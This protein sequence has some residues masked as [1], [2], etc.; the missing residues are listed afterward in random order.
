VEGAGGS[1][2]V[3]LLSSIVARTFAGRIPVSDQAIEQ[4][5]EGFVYHE[6]DWWGDWLAGCQ[7]HIAAGP[8]TSEVAP[9]VTADTFPRFLASALIDILEA[10]SLDSLRFIEEVANSYRICID[11]NE[12]DLAQDYES[13]SPIEARVTLI[14]LARIARTFNP[15]WR[16]HSKANVVS[17]AVWLASQGGTRSKRALARLSKKWEHNL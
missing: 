6:G 16:P 5:K 3:N 8:I 17:Y 7:N 9:Y 13:L 10:D 4:F 14:C 15:D 2:I 12:E 11:E 1:R